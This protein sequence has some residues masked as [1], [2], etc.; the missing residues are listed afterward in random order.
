MVR[1]VTILACLILSSLQADA[2]GKR[3]ALVIGNSAYIHAGPLTNPRNDAADMIAALKERDFEVLEGLDLDKV[4]F[5]RKVRD[6]ARALTNA[7]VGVFFYAG[8]GLQ[9]AGKNYL[10]P[11]DAELGT[12]EALDFEMI[13]L[14]IVQRIMERQV[15]TNI[16][17]L[18][19]C[20]NNP[21]GAQSC[22]RHGYAFCR[23]WDRSCAYGE[24]GR[25][26]DQFFHTAR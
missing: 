16:L 18:D 8:H 3:A 11:T 20:R 23:N 10:V 26:S 25:H 13:Q 24:R 5:D 4:A 17:F 15:P 2:Q 19:A 12:P 6:F 1:F 14:D 21:P 22:T 7:E 9:V